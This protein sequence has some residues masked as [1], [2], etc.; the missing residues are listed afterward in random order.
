MDLLVLAC[1]DVLDGS[2]AA[3]S[4]PALVGRL[5]RFL[6]GGVQDERVV[7]DVDV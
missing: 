4:G 3:R 5:G 6:A 7:V 1:L 2:F